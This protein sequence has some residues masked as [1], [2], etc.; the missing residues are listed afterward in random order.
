MSSRRDGLDLVGQHTDN[1]RV[2]QDVTITNTSRDRSVVT[3]SRAKH[4][5]HTHTHTLFGLVTAAMVDQD[6]FI[7]HL[8]PIV[9]D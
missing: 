3:F 4:Q 1:E 8:D 7:N 2:L 6:C 5:G 9:K